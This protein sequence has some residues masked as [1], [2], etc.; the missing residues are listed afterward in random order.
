MAQ[1]IYTSGNFIIID[2]NGVVRPYS[3]K[4]SNYDE[5][6]SN[7]APSEFLIENLITK[8][9]K[10]ILFTEAD[11]WENDSAAAVNL[12]G[13]LNVVNLSNAIIG[14]GTKFLKELS[15]GDLIK[16]AGVDYTVDTITDNNNATLTIVYAGATA[17]DLIVQIYR[18]FY[19]EDTLR[20][21]LQNNTSA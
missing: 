11:E 19:T 3:K 1:K 4:N 8:G 15:V 14:V 20:T 21:F 6:P 12:T 18:T 5:L 17:N 16:I 13:T 2:I 9:R 7:A 10:K